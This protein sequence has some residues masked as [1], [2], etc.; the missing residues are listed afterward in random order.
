[1]LCGR[2]VKKGVYDP[3]MK[4]LASVLRLRWTRQKAAEQCI[5]VHN[6]A[7]AL[8]DYF[9]VALFLFLM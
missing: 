2:S 5:W 8:L 9:A 7:L 3:M 1:M 6:E 4:R